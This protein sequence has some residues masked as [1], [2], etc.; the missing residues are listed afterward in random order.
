MLHQLRL[1]HLKALVVVSFLTSTAWTAAPAQNLPALPAPPQLPGLADLPSLPQVPTLP[2]APKPPKPPSPPKL[3]SPPRLPS[4]P[5]LPNPPALPELPAPPQ[6]PQL[7]GVGQIPGLPGAPGAPMIGFP[8]AGGNARGQVGGMRN[9]LPPTTLDSFVYEAAERAEEIYG[10]EAERGEIPP[11]NSFTKEHRINAG[12][13]GTRDAGLTT[14]H[15]SYLPDAWGADEFI[16]DEWDQSGANGGTGGGTGGYNAG[17]N[18][19]NYGNFGMTS[20]MDLGFL[21]L[22]SAGSGIGSSNSNS[23]A[24]AGGSSFTLP[25]IPAPPALPSPPT[26]ADLGIP[27]PSQ[28]GQS[29]F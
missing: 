2:D 22:G 27:S 23:G 12:I 21:G 20:G 13:T 10:D 9:G 18:P 28:G 19:G 3:P 25:A 17:V 7:P 15:G 6:P 5:D 4:P 16:G 11:Y 8:G 14:G 26:L 1:S 24:A 29:G